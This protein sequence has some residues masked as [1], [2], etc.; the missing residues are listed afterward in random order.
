MSE[1]VILRCVA[2]DTNLSVQLTLVGV[3]GS[4]LRWLF[5]PGGSTKHRDSVC[6]KLRHRSLQSLVALEHLLV[7]RCLTR[8][9]A[10]G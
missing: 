1:S 9:A 2:D 4:L 6:Q 7:Q 8:V 3:L 5:I 10:L